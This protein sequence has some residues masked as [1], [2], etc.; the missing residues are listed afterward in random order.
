MSVNRRPVKAG[1]GGNLVQRLAV[2]YQFAD[3]FLQFFVCTDRA[4]HE[5]DATA[6]FDHPQSTF[7]RQRQYETKKMCAE[8][9]K[10]VAG[11]GFFVSHPF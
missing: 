1:R 9:E 11:G 8:T 7:L 6:N 2:E 4:S 10:G 3:G 5:R